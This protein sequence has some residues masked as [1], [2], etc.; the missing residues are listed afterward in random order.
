MPKLVRGTGLALAADTDAVSESLDR[1]SR[2]AAE[3]LV[4]RRIRPLLRWARE[5]AGTIRRTPGSESRE[6]GWELGAW[7]RIG[8]GAYQ[9]QTQIKRR[10]CARVEIERAVGAHFG[11]P[12]AIPQEGVQNE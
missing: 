4:C 11:E 12:V 8:W 7:I 6:E 3:P 2:S 10:K 1:T 9:I 5:S